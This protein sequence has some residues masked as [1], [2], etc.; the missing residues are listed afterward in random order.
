MLLYFSG[1]PNSAMGRGEFNGVAEE[2][3]EELLDAIAI[4]LEFDIYR[5]SN[6]C[7]LGVL[8]H[9]LHDRCRLLEKIGKIADLGMQGK[10]V[11]LHTL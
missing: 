7:N 6:E 10:S 5:L 3:G 8:G 4:D 11:G 9:S 2:I 1:K